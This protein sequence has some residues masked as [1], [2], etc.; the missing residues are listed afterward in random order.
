MRA[1]HTDVA[2]KPMD[3]KARK[4]ARRATFEYNAGMTKLLKEKRRAAKE[5]AAEK[6]AEELNA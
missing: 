6:A 4:F 5:A 2:G 1:Y 3:R